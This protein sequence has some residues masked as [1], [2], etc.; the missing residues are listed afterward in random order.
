MSIRAQLF[1]IFVGLALFFII[2][3]LVRRKRLQEQSSLL[4]LAAG[5]LMALIPVWKEG[6]FAFSHFMGIENAAS[7]IFLLGFVFVILVLLHLS[8]L[9]SRLT[10]ENREFAQT[11]CLLREQ[12]ERS[13]EE[14]AT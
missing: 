10:E 5:F 3:G 11:I 9:T 6:F 1:S 4:W 14:E 2:M 12:L 13:R 8:V 7:A